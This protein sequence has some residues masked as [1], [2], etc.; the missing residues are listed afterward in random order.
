MNN[1]FASPMPSSLNRYLLVG[2]AFLWWLAFWTEA[3]AQYDE[4]EIKSVQI[5]TFAKNVTWSE[6]VMKG[7][8]KITIGV[9]GESPFGEALDRVVKN[10]PING[11]QL[12]IKYGNLLRELKGS[13]IIFICKSEEP[14]IKKILE[15]I[16]GTYKN[17][18]V[19][20]IG[21]NI[22]NFCEYGG[23]IN[24]T[25][26]KYLFQINLKAASDA[27]LIIS[28][29]LLRIAKEIIATQTNK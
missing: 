10:R 24:F 9:L 1:L 25:E 6:K 4:Y 20:T 27:D 15:E 16:S 3:R 21:D 8:T 19:L 13:N 18:S 22:A 29:Q 26:E 28:S 14:N 17:V 5:Y 7:Q 12:E 2:V 23:I 11:R